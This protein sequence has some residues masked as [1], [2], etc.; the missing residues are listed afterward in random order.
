MVPC[1]ARC[2]LREI[3]WVAA[4]C[5]STAAAIADFRKLFYGAADVLDGANGLLRRRLNA[6]DLLADFG[7]GLCCLLGKRLYF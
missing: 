2:T 7:G 5:C 4:P 6:I 3:S 1:A